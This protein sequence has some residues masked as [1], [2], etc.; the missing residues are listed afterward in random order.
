MT[1]D[2]EPRLLLLHA[3]R[4]LGF[5]DTAVIAARARITMGAAADLLRKAE[6]LGWVQHVSFADLRGWS[7]TD[8]G[9]I[10]NERQLATE[11]ESA[12][13][14]HQIAATYRAFLP[15]NSRLLRAVTDW[16]IAPTDTD[17]FAPND[18]SDGHRDERILAELTELSAALVPLVERLSDVLARFDGYPERFHV[19]LNK[20]KDGHLEWIDRTDIDSC[21][22]VWFELH[23]DLVATLSIDRRTE[24]TDGSE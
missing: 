6:R 18:H 19:A 11:R 10:E 8:T 3:V 12:D 23:E 7:L 17:A 14:E 16:Q 4:L 5:A 21:H 22:R 9:R 13:P 24:N 1:C 20:A 2:S 15:L